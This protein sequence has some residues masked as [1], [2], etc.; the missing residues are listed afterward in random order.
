M[1]A[2]SGGPIVLPFPT[3]V[4]FT[5]ELSHHDALLAI[6]NGRIVIATFHSN[7]ERG[8]LKEVMQPELVEGLKEAWAKV[9]REGW[10][11]AEGEGV[12]VGVSEVDSDPYVVVRVPRKEEGKLSA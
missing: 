3:D 1:C 9:R 5:G 7:S 11:G 12:E 6:E 10:E 4:I 8:F 2:G